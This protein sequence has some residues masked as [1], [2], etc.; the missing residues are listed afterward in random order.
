M[1]L[2]KERN[3]G[4]ERMDKETLKDVQYGLIDHPIEACCV[5]IHLNQT[6]Q[7]KKTFNNRQFGDWDIVQFKHL[8]SSSPDNQSIVE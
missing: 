1:K 2:E 7:F 3:Q 5:Y 6:N 4:R 8:Q